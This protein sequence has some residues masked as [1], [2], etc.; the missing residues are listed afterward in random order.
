[1]FI[2]N[3][4]SISIGSSDS[5]SIPLIEPEDM[6]EEFVCDDDW[7]DCLESNDDFLD[8]DPLRECDSSLMV[9]E[10]DNLSIVEARGSTDV[11]DTNELLLES[12]LPVR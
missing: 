2:I 12:V 6:S 11:V 8:D 9:S 7:E 4:L 5:V 1:M 3:G 10:V